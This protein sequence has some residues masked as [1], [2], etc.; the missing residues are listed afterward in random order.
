MTMFYTTRSSLPRQLPIFASQ[1]STP[2]ART[3]F[4]CFARAPQNVAAPFVAS[5][6]D[7]GEANSTIA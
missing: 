1:K 3:P 2:C 7:S 6:A 4:T 5:L